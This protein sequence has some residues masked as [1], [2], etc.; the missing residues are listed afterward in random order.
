M[1][2]AIVAARLLQFAAALV[3]FGSPLFYL[4]GLKPAAGVESR[5][6]MW[7][8][9]TVLI[10]AVVAIIGVAWWVAAQAALIFPDSGVFDWN[11]MSTLLTDTRFGRV[12]ALR[13]GLLAIAVALLIL[14][15]PGRALWLVQA[16]L[17]GAIVASFA[18]TGHGVRDEG[19]AGLV[20]LSGD[21]LHLLAAAV[22]IGALAPLSVLILQ[23]LRIGNEFSVRMTYEALETFSGIGPAVVAI[24][25]LTGLVNSWFLIG[26]ENW[27]ELF[28]SAYGVALIVK[29]ILFGG[30]LL[31]AAVN[32]FWL[33]PRLGKNLTASR[34]GA[35]A[36]R[37][38][39]VSVSTET[40]LAVLVLAAVALF[41][42]LEPP[43]AT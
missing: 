38:L 2:W 26:L 1:N 40:A 19:V 18:W 14:M 36:L 33:S 42:T 15:K 21:V 5:R 41:G 13:L 7:P 25:I 27:R 23:S 6:W 22:W 30:M 9:I 16:V 37:A 39:R 28:T 12:T 35:D 29:L 17:G 32:R 34:S 3:L 8:H 31:L 24:L 10:A 20:H 4:Y 43:I 11:A